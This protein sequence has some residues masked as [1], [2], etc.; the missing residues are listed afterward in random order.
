MAS[1]YRPAAGKGRRETGVTNGWRQTPRAALSK[2]VYWPKKTNRFVPI[3][4]ERCFATITSAEP[5]S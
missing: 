3:G 1:V 2:R 4:P 5:L